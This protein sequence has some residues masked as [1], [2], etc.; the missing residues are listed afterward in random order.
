[1][2]VWLK[3]TNMVLLLSLPMPFLSK[4]IP[5]ESLTTPPTPRTLITLCPLSDGNMTPTPPLTNVT[6]LSETV[7]E[8]IGVKWDSS[9]SKWD[10][11]YWALDPKLHGPHLDHGPTTTLPVRDAVRFVRKEHVIRFA[12]V[13]RH[14][15]MTYNTF[16]KNGDVL[17]YLQ[18]S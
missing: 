18:G 2:K 9:I 7:G 14:Y 3:F 8:N 13:C 4:P 15:M 6:G 11:T 5:E 12:C 16:D 10:S 1:M 17:T